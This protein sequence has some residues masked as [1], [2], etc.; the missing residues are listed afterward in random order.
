MHQQWPACMTTV[1]LSISNVKIGFNSFWMVTSGHHSRHGNPLSQLQSF[2]TH[3]RHIS[4]EWPIFLLNGDFWVRFC[5]QHKNFWACILRLRLN[6][7]SFLSYLLPTIDAINIIEFHLMLF[8]LLFIFMFQS[9]RCY[10]K[11]SPAS[12][13]VMR[14]CV[15]HSNIFLSSSLS[16]SSSS[17]FLVY[18]TTSFL[19]CI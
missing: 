17:P 9:R 13:C 14:I 8:L 18:S 4:G 15:R 7:I 2:A 5:F 12:V 1:S 6:L 16:P 10:S 19:L 11:R 3:F